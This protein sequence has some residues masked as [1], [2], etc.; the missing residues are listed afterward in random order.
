MDPD[1]LRLALLAG[2]RAIE[3]NRRLHGTIFCHDPFGNCQELPYLEAAKILREAADGQI[4]PAP[5]AR[6]AG[7]SEWISVKDRLPERAVP[8]LICNP[9]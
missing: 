7:M 3:N 1:K 4:C 5:Q 6:V 2:A 9:C 8:V